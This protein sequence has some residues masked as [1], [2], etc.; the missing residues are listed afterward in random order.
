MVATA[1]TNILTLNA[2]SGHSRIFTGYN[3][4]IFYSLSNPSR[5]I[6]EQYLNLGRD[7]VFSNPSQGIIHPVSFIIMYKVCL[8]SNA[9]A[10]ITFFVNN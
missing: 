8:K 1:W 4:Q 7:H 6:P 10:V 2:T 3:G 5:Q 9:T